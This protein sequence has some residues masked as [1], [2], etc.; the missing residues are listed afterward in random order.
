METIKG[1]FN[2]GVVLLSS[3][4]KVIGMNAYARQILGPAVSD[5]GKTVF[6]YHSRTDHKKIDLLLKEFCA[7]D[8]YMP[9]AMILDV[10]NKFLLVNLSRVDMH[11]NFSDQLFSMTFID[12]TEQTGAR[13]NPKSHLVQIDKFP[14]FFKNSYLILSTSSIYFIK[15]DGNYCIV[16]TK[17]RSYYLILTLK[18]VL[19]R[20][21]G[22]NFFM[23]HKSYIVNLDHIRCINRKK[24]GNSYILF[25]NDNI[26]PV[27]VARRRTKD[28]RAAIVPVGRS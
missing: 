13:V 14:V 17:K 25:D 8:F 12:V 24:D 7:G 2:I 9:V 4:F 16:F 19:E 1:T 21:S 5:L 28:L 11:E 3:N 22:S 20:Y 6:E 26:P 27:P 15:S 23:V 18:S 10:L